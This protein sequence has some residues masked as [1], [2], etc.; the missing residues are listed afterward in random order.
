MTE[1]KPRAWVGDQVYDA[2]AGKEGIVSDVKR[3]GTYILR[4]VNSFALRWEAPSAV[5]LTVTVSRLERVE[6]ER[7]A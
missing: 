4:E 5:K 2:S 6:K 3:D 1:G 7:G